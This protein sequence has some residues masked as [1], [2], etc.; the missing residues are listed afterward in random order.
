MNDSSFQLFSLKTSNLKSQNPKNKDLQCHE[1]NKA[2][3]R[4]NPS[5]SIAHS[6]SAVAPS[7]PPA[8]LRISLAC[9]AGSFSVLLPS[10]PLL[11]CFPSSAALPPV[12]SAS[13]SELLFRRF[14]LLCFLVL[15]TAADF[16]FGDTDLIL[17]RII[18][19]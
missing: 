17:Q 14:S 4:N 10:A 9:A 18:A 15:L 8:P 1:K 5:P 7:T 3:T 12:C 6:S 11:F 13:T 2:A 16:E 19:V